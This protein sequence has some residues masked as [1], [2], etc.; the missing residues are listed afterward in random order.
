MKK[1]IVCTFLVSI[2][3]LFAI[4]SSGTQ[5]VRAQSTTVV[6]VD[7]PIVID[8]ELV[9]GKSFSINVTIANVTD[10]YG[11]KFKLCY[12]N[13]ILTSLGVVIVPF[14][15][16]TDY[17]SNMSIE[18]KEGFIWVNVTYHSPAEPLTT[19]DPVTLATIS[20]QVRAFGI[21][22]LDLCYTKLIDEEGNPID[23]SVE[24]GYFRPP[25]IPGDIND[26][27]V[28][29]AMDV[30]IV[31]LAFASYPGH[32]RWNPDADIA[33]PWDLIDVMDLLIVGINFGK[34]W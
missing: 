8:P 25:P 21:T 17:T 23:H 9:L 3:L 4:L 32:P 19:T 20:F 16:Q 30:L 29:D 6:S 15:N 12:N 2:F 13:T 18:H 27:G 5:K 10:L 14:P 24:N 31:G 26:D 7:P 33:E 28:V 1:K 11:F 34:T 22:D